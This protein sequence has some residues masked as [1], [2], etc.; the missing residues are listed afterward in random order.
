[1]H[2]LVKKNKLFFDHYKIK[3]SIGKR[4]IGVKKSEGDQITPKGKFRINLILYR[5]DR[6]PNFKTKIKKLPIEKNMGWCDDPF[7]KNYNKIVKLPIKHSA[8]R[9]YRKDNVYDLVLVLNY[10]V[11]PI[12][13]GKG[14]A[15]FIH[16]A[17]RKYK[18]TLGCVA[19]SKKSIKKI[20]KKIKKSS[21]IHIV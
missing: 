20:A 19:I 7:S 2:I 11:N 5:K 15:I 17:K 6:I 4:G 1:M 18:K 21:L 13:K 16:I 3:C 9:L 12:R 10:N 14:S 8:E